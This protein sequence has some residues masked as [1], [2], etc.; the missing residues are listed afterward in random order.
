VD[1]IDLSAILKRVHI[2]ASDFSN[3]VQLKPLG[4]TD[5]TGFLEVS[6]DGNPAHAQIVAQLDGAAWQLVPN[7]G[8]L[9]AVSTLHRS[10]FIL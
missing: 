1:K 6:P 7:G 2:T 9:Q 3:Y 10:D 4:P 5:Y 8:T